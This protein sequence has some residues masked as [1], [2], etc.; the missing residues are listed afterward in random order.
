M[1]NFRFF[2]LI[3]KNSKKKRNSNLNSKFQ[4]EVL[5]L[6]YPPRVTKLA[7]LSDSDAPSKKVPCAP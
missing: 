1:R 3:Y 7:T 2:I 5:S 4:I 6:L